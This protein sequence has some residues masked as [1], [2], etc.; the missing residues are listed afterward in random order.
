MSKVW[1]RKQIFGQ[2]RFTLAFYNDD[3]DDDG[4]Q[5]SQDL[6][7]I[8][9]LPRFGDDEPEVRPPRL[10][11]CGREYSV[12]R[13]EANI[14]INLPWIS[15]EHGTFLVG[16]HTDND[17]FDV[18]K[19]PTLEYTGA[20]GCII[21]RD[22]ET[23]QTPKGGTAVLRHGDQISL[24]VKMKS[25]ISLAWSDTT[26]FVESVDY[27]KLNDCAS[28]GIKLCVEYDPKMNR[29]ITEE[30]T[31]E[32][33]QLPILL[34]GGCLVT[35]E[36]ALELFRRA[37]LAS[38]LPSTDIVSLED[39]CHLPP[40]DNFLPL[41]SQ[42]LPRQLRIP[43]IW[44]AND[45]RC[46]LLSNRIFVF[47]VEGKT[48]PTVWRNVMSAGDAT[49]EVVNVHE[50]STKWMARLT[51]LR[52][53]A[54]ESSSTIVLITDEEA[55]FAA[56]GELWKD[57]VRDTDRIGLRFL[58]YSK[59]SEAVLWVRQDALQSEFDPGD[60][61]SQLSEHV[62]DSFAGGTSSIDVTQEKRVRRRREQ[63]ET[64][65]VVP[66]R[67][68]S[69][70]PS[71][72]VS[73][74]EDEYSSA[75]AKLKRR[76]RQPSVE[77]APASQVTS[78]SRDETPAPTLKILQTPA[79]LDRTKLK[80]RDRAQASQLEDFSQNEESLIE[81][82]RKVFEQTNPSRQTL[83]QISEEGHSM[84]LA[85]RVEAADRE[86][87]RALETMTQAPRKRK[88]QE[89]QEVEENGSQVPEP[90]QPSRA[91]STTPRDSREPP[92]KKRA[93]QRSGK[94]KLA[95][96]QEE[97]EPRTQLKNDPAKKAPKPATQTDRD[98]KYLLALASLKKGKKREDQFD[99]DFNSLR[100]AKPDRDKID[101]VDIEQLAYELLPIDMNIRG[102]FMVC[103]PTIVPRQNTQVQKRR[104]GNST[105]LG[106]PDF[107][108]FKKKIS[109]NR[110]PIVALVA[111]LSL[112]SIDGSH[113]MLTRPLAKNSAGAELEEDDNQSGGRRI[114][115]PNAQV[116]ADSDDDFGSNVGLG[117][118]DGKKKANARPA[119]ARQPEP[120]FI[121]DSDQESERGAGSVDESDDDKAKK[122]AAAASGKRKA[123][124]LA[125]SSS[126]DEGY[127]ARRKRR[128]PAYIST[129]W[130]RPQLAFP[131]R[132]MSSGDNAETIEEARAEMIAAREV[133]MLQLIEERK[134]LAKHIFA[135]TKIPGA[136]LRLPNAT[137]VDSEQ[138]EQYMAEYPMTPEL[139]V[140]FGQFS[141]AKLPP[142]DFMLG[143]QAP[144]TVGLQG[145]NSQLS[146][147]SVKI[148]AHEEE[149]E[150][151][152]IEE[153]EMDI[154]EMQD[155]NAPYR[156]KLNLTKLSRQHVKPERPAMFASKYASSLPVPPPH[157][158]TK[159]INRSNDVS[160]R[161]SNSEKPIKSDLSQ[162]SQPMTFSWWHATITH[163]PTYK[164]VRKAS[165]CL[166]TAE[167]N[168]AI[169]ELILYQ[170][171]ERIDQLKNANQW[172]F[173]QPKRQVIAQAKDHW[174]YLLDEAKWMQAD[175]QEEKKWKMTVALEL[176]Q[177]AVEWYEATPDERVSLRGFYRPPEAAD[178]AEPIERGVP[179]DEDGEEPDLSSQI[180]VPETISDKESKEEVEA[181]VSVP[182]DE[183]VAMLPSTSSEAP[184]TAP[185]PAQEPTFTMK[186][187]EPESIGLHDVPMKTGT[188]A[189]AEP[190][191]P[192][193]DTKNPIVYA[194]KSEPE[195]ASNQYLKLRKP[196]TGL[197]A[198]SLWADPAE[199]KTKD[200][201]R[202][203]NTEAPLSWDTLF[204]DLPRY[205]VPSTPESSDNVVMR[206]DEVQTTSIP[207]SRF[208]DSQ[209]LLM[210]V[211]QPSSHLENGH[212]KRFDWEP[213]TANEG[214][215]GK[216]ET[217]FGKK[218]YDSYIQFVQ[219]CISSG[220]RSCAW[221]P[222]DD[223]LLKKLAPELSYNWPLIADAF[224]F[225]NHS[226]H[227]E[228][229]TPPQC[230][231]R[232]D[233]CFGDEDKASQ[234]HD[235][236]AIIERTPKSYP[237][238]QR[239]PKAVEDFV[240]SAGPNDDDAK[241]M[242]H[243]FVHRAIK[244]MMKRRE[245]EVKSRDIPQRVM[246][247]HTSHDAIIKSK[248]LTPQEIG[249][250]KHES[251]Q[252]KLFE[253]KRRQM[254]MH[255]QARLRQ[256][257]QQALASG[258]LAPGQVA[259]AA[260][261][262]PNPQLTANGVGIPAGGIPLPVRLQ[263]GGVPNI[264]QQGVGMLAAGIQR[265]PNGEPMNPTTLMLLQ[266]QQQNQQRMNA[267]AAAAA[268]MA[269]GTP[270]R[271]QSAATILSQGAMG[272][273]SP[274]NTHLLRMQQDPV[275]RQ[276]Q[277]NVL[278]QQ[279]GQ[280]PMISNDPM[281]LY[282]QQQQALAQRAA[283][284][285]MAA[286]FQ[287][288][289][290]QQQQQMAMQQTPSVSQLPPGM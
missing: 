23:I 284:Q 125:A 29:H 155:G 213:V 44:Q 195:Q 111:N 145:S 209:P 8:I 6:M 47:L 154:E 104:E 20:K 50:G 235:P 101:D 207:V 1:P 124:V 3:D 164:L 247:P 168:T 218:R 5:R 219:T 134:A 202:E 130:T 122:A 86:R 149:E 32:P 108:K 255:Q 99:R 31:G 148:E 279:M 216:F 65:V 17:V 253:I 160:S 18:Q 223:A 114:G 59:I 119:R 289:Q 156:L 129:I 79:S 116:A 283:A 150:E 96:V 203:A 248:V 98:D 42:N 190:L 264:S 9:T 185:N 191:P 186:T 277:A 173:V 244:R 73:V 200:S 49:Y 237:P 228:R 115:K 62:P 140:S 176:A 270:P 30:I 266:Q 14:I 82:H 276:M 43:E 196:I 167:W 15:R 251:E 231:V 177:A 208:A 95:A 189:D 110:A 76:V 254:E 27:I 174:A 126:E 222:S 170:A 193:D 10:L 141:T 188:E 212:W 257:H 81:R 93:I 224:N 94:S 40:T 75:R 105:W 7:W 152:K 90:S 238:G 187:E 169:Q 262:L 26:W 274:Q 127:V 178:M 163:N 35:K 85:E 166:T 182:P 34:R 236:P 12:G 121:P 91:R 280:M 201:A 36:W 246:V 192:P 290:M 24:T 77:P 273:A 139:F 63:S 272:T 151:D 226:N 234:P 133:R 179:Q 147:P 56:V 131:A 67:V 102:N 275:Y 233:I 74:N 256:Q 16:E 199:L 143:P 54:R 71:D 269:N 161:P 183:D 89:V 88:A 271:P 287:H 97:E 92:T 239:R 113:E 241:F 53:K 13:K 268:A 229:R 132:V 261:G 72:V 250:Q 259:I 180:M 285:Q 41:F 158:L 128:V 46:T 217:N 80:R 25:P 282:R 197:D 153:D 278:A 172:S 157:L 230:H 78:F 243:K 242:R 120:L 11:K 106:R 107:K 58:A 57:F 48:L 184:P 55:M 205:D 265:V 52:G 103:E 138:F 38:G 33:S 61:T 286:T 84:S 281:A 198:G 159:D 165:K 66:E 210:S 214:D 260:N 21:L 22:G 45:A 4:R 225:I 144:S 206:D 162:G 181:Q 245:E 19:I 194:I 64:P 211:L 240:P 288:Q 100:I 258:L 37:N 249:R 175:F 263:Q 118:G 136:L 2:T 109:S 69:V 215:H 142:E 51:L 227:M 123:V 135:I 267:A 68:A 171:F 220:P 117:N 83:S 252:K 221:F 60:A 87:Q 146:I 204:P 39:A 137:D 70:A 112:N 28:I 232:Y